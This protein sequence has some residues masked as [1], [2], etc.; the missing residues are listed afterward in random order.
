MEQIID[1]PVFIIQTGFQEYAVYNA[2]NERLYVGPRDEAEAFYSDCLT[3][4]QRDIVKDEAAVNEILF[5][6]NKI[7]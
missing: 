1:L 7:Y 4:E 5:W 6:E 2:D 3:P